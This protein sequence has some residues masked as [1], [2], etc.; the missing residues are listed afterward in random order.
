MHHAT[1]FHHRNPCC[2]RQ[3]LALVMRHEH[4]RST[5]GAVYATELLL[6][7]LPQLEVK[8]SQRFVQQQNLGIHD[9][10]SRQGDALLLSTRQLLGKMVL[11]PLEANQSHRL[12]DTF[13]DCITVKFLQAQ[14]IADILSC[15]HMRKQPIALKHHVDRSMFRPEIGDILT[16]N[17]NPAA[18]RRN[19]PT[20]HAQQRR[21]AT[22]RRTQDR[23]ELAP[24]DVE[25]NRVHRRDRTEAP[26][27]SSQSDR[28]FPLCHNALIPL[29]I[30]GHFRSLVIRL[31]ELYSLRS[32]TQSLEAASMSSQTRWHIVTDSRDRLGE[33]PQWSS[34]TGDLF[35]V[36]FYGP[37]IHRLSS[38]GERQDWTLEGFSS[39]GSL[40]QC[41]KD[42]LLVAMGRGLYLF[43]TKD[44]SITPFADPNQGRNEVSYNDGKVD[45]H[46]RYWVGTYDTTESAPRGILYSLDRT[47]AWSIG[48]SGFVVCNG[49]AFSPE[50]D[51]L[52]FNDSNGRQTLAYDLDLEA[53]T[54]TK[55]RLIQRYAES[56]GIPDGLC[57]DSAGEIWCALYGGGK[58]IRLSPDGELR[59]C[60]ELPVPN[61]TACCLGGADFRTLFVT[62]GRD[63]GG[64]GGAVFATSVDIP[65]LPEPVFDPISGAT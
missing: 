20:K 65:G 52:Y 25:I 31:V 10:R 44:E 38:D 3:G 36:D 16:I 37:T 6:H 62:T 57:V 33:S 7:G 43:N 11:E 8:C 47:G 15:R 59:Q 9:K 61:V 39:I 58:V 32:K 63:G 21:L 17:L 23:K 48:D 2:E 27:Q 5:N 22:A 41:T 53:G 50:G 14:A 42:H 30:P 55:R 18:G 4:K 54:L 64:D 56:E 12:P 28:D 40:V 46:G 60:L 51:I 13:G 26:S 34:V 45:R 24:H 49:P 19:E 35:W 1:V 29:Q